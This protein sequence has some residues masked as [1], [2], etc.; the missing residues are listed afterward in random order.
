MKISLILTL[1]FLVQ[2]VFSQKTDTIFLLKTTNNSVYIEP[3][4]NSVQ[5]K[6]LTKTKDRNTYIPIYQYRGKYYLY[7]PCDWI[8]H[9]TITIRNDSVVIRMGEEIISY[10]IQNKKKGNYHLQDSGVKLSIKIIDK[11]KG[12]SIVKLGSPNSADNYFLMV[13]AYK[14][15]KY[16][17]IVNSCPYN[18]A[19]EFEF[20]N[21]DL[22]KLFNTQ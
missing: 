12:T 8:W 17:V 4:I 9:K 2:N 3:D 22:E 6:I 14:S 18:K 11:K 19:E 1:V 15:G 21:I 20:D 16:P 13:N 10:K 5:A 7:A